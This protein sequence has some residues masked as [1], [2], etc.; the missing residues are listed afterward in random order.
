VLRFLA[1]DLLI[2]KYISLSKLSLYIG[3]GLVALAGSLSAVPQ[4]L[5]EGLADENY[6]AR[7]KAENDLAQWAKARGEKSIKELDGIKQ[8]ASSPE[9]K[10]RLD[11]VISGVNVYK[12]I[13]GTRGFM[14]ITMNQI[15]GGAIIDTVS[16]GTPAEKSGLQVNDLIVELDGVD[17]TEKKAHVNEAMDFIRAY[18]KSKN[19]GQKLRIKIEREGK[20]MDKELK[21][22]DYDEFIAQN[23]PWGGGFNNGGN[24]VIPLPGNMRMQQRNLDPMQIK[25]NQLLQ[26]EMNLK[27]QKGVLKDKDLPEELKQLIELQTKASQKRIEDLKKELLRK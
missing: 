1:K 10:S 13:P 20:L 12:A 5:I 24:Q 3:V 23:D 4:E 9:V 27:F 25:E 18:V 8:K 14:G 17:L 26:L 19:A 22:A 16:P 15:L 21:L 7:E 2:M 6:H 11:N